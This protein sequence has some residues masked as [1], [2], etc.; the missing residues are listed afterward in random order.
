MVGAGGSGQVLDKADLQLGVDRVS[1]AV[2]IDA[3]YDV[4]LA[5]GVDLD[6]TAVLTHLRF[7]LFDLRSSTATSSPAPLCGRTTATNSWGS[8]FLSRLLRCWSAWQHHWPRAVEFVVKADVISSIDRHQSQLHRE[9]AAVM[10][11]SSRRVIPIGVIS[12]VAVVATSAVVQAQVASWTVPVSGF[13]RSCQ[14]LDA[15]WSSNSGGCGSLRQT[16]RIRHWLSEQSW[17]GRSVGQ[18]C[19]R[20]RFHRRRCRHH[21]PR[22]PHQ[23]RRG[24]RRCPS[25]GC[26]ATTPV[27]G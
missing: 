7:Q 18:Q 5:N 8:V 16:G 2:R 12:A 6:G 17:G 25:Y 3:G 13:L 15:E 10:R 19:R 9:K 26:L 14:Q 24:S 20:H 4:P 1:P 27:H 11:R 23:R 22:V 21:Q